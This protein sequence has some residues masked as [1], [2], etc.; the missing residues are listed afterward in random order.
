MFGLATKPLVKPE[1]QKVLLADHPTT[2]EYDALARELTLDLPQLRTNRFLEYMAKHDLPIYDLPTVV[3]YMDRI[4]KRD[5]DGNGWLW[6]P[7]GTEDANTAFMRN[8]SFGTRA[9]GRKGSSDFFLYMNHIGTYTHPIPMRVLQRAKL[10]KD[11]SHGTTRPIM[12][13]SDYTTKLDLPYRPNTPD[14]KPHACK[15][16]RPVLRTED[17]AYPPSAY[18][19]GAADA[20][21]CNQETGGPQ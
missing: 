21:R 12:F 4:A 6:R 7:M 11:Y 3:A 8:V 16:A 15:P 5:G 2:A 1:P 10:I 9:S 17:D 19:L 13:I 18:G 14:P 20:T